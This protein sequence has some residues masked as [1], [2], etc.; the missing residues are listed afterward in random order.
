[1]PR[2]LHIALYCIILI[3]SIAPLA[4]QNMAEEPDL[5]RIADDLK[6]ENAR[7]FYDMKLYDQSLRD[8]NEYLEVFSRGFHRKE[9]YMTIADIH[10]KRYE[11]R[12]AARAYTRLYEEFN[13]SD[14]GLQAFFNAAICHEKMG[15]E[16]KAGEIYTQILE[17]HPDS[18]QAT[19]AQTQMEILGIIGRRQ[20][21]E[22]K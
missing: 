17:D 7:H 22:S 4:A 5:S 8:M 3:S 18:Q 6:Y 14:E 12:K 15:N 9:A 21:G 13:T 16:K 2:P 1:M 20:T 11:Y 10:F 19:M